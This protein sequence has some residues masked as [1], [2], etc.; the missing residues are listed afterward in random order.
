VNNPSLRTVAWAAKRGFD[1]VVSATAL[2]VLLPVLALCAIAVY[3][4]GGTPVLFR[5]RRVGTDGQTFDCLKFRSMRPDN[6]GE[7]A[8]RWS[9]ADDPGWA[10][11]ARSCGAPVSTSCPSCGTCCAAT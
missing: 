2:V 11:W 6:A 3:C 1:I 4:E 7:S 9:I 5:Q 10:R 8:T